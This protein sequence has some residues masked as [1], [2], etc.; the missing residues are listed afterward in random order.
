M[1]SRSISAYMRIAVRSL[2]LGVAA[3]LAA[4]RSA[5]TDTIR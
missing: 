1:P 4:R 3:K 5:P 2:Q